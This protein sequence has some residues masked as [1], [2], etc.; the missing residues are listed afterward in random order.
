M[1]SMPEKHIPYFALVDALETSGCPICTQ[2]ETGLKKYLDTLL[3]E[4]INDVGFR[5][6]L[7]KNRGF[8]SYH[9][10][11]FRACNDGLAVALTHRN[12]LADA[13]EAA[14]SRR[15][16]RPRHAAEQC[17]LCELIAES[18]TRHLAVLI[19][20]I[21]DENLQN[22]FLGSDG[23]CLP[24]FKRLLEKCK[25]VPAWLREFQIRRYRELLVAIDTFIDACNAST[26]RTEASLSPKEKNA[27]KNVIDMLYGRKEIRPNP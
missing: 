15:Q 25:N 23:L 12:L 4:G 6:R 21:E 13:I 3:Y 1:S 5:R 16:N 19:D 18:E 2:V 22:A 26:P 11:L 14:A 9:A 7:R 17:L 24:H 27:W 10:H 20:F 8:C